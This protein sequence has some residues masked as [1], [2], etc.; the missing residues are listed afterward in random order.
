[1]PGNS[2]RRPSR[3]M[4][5]ERPVNCC[6]YL[7]NEFRTTRE[8]KGNGK[9]GQHPIKRSRELA[10][11][12][13]LPVVIPVIDVRGASTIGVGV[14]LGVQR[15][16][17]RA[18]RANARQCRQRLPEADPLQTCEDVPIMVSAG[19]PTSTPTISNISGEESVVRFEVG[20]FVGRLSEPPCPGHGRWRC[21]RA[22]RGNRCSREC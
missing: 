19:F 16:R 2:P 9:Q 14:P 22:A 1:L 5:G 10:C 12:P 17:N 7:S 13:E 20:C 6:P 11:S 8:D 21:T 3:G 15:L 18:V 4:P